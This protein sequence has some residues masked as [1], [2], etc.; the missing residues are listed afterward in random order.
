MRAILLALAL[1]TALGA[2]ELTPVGPLPYD[3]SH[4]KPRAGCTHRLTGQIEADDLAKVQAIPTDPQVVLCLDSP[5]GAFRTGVQIGAFIRDAGIGTRLEENAI[6]ES[7]CALI[8]MS[9]SYVSDSPRYALQPYGMTEEEEWLLGLQPWRTMHPTA[10][11]G[12]HAPRLTVPAGQYD[13]A[14]VQ[15][16]YDIALLGLSEFTSQLMQ[17]SDYESETVA[18]DPDLFARMIA[19]PHDTM[20]YIDTVEKA[21]RYRI[22]IGPIANPPSAPDDQTLIRACANAMGW[23]EGFGSYLYED[24]IP[25]ATLRG[26][27]VELSNGLP[28]DFERGG[29]DSQWRMFRYDVPDI[30]FFDPATPLAALA[31]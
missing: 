18:W 1:P 24:G 31:P 21:G 19:T 22:D 12:F 8:F 4:P 5:G 25:G 29:R 2:A 28:C 30:T 10:R 11:L 7:A 9:G 6:C 14:T 16:A 13:E 17:P 27:S 15:R 20:F 26:T 23:G 3:D